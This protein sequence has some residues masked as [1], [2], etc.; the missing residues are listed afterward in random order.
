MVTPWE[1][2]WAFLGEYDVSWAL[3]RLERA[4]SW[5]A[6]KYTAFQ[7]NLADLTLTCQVASSQGGQG[8]P[9]SS[10]ILSHHIFMPPA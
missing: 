10:E 4:G 6:Q 5:L 3:G 7:L 1:T 8:F 9:D 2:T